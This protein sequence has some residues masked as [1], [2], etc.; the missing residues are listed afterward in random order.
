MHV[1]GSADPATTAAL[2]HEMALTA[3]A[4][5]A[6]H[7]GPRRLWAASV[8][9]G[10]DDRHIPRRK[11]D[12]FPREDGELYRRQWEAA[13]TSHSDQVLVVSFNEWME[14]TNIEPNAAWGDQYLELTSVLAARF[15]DR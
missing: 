2:D 15:R 3:R 9:P 5:A 6:V 8:L 13:T 14:T 4:W 12:H 7:G 11:P 1:Y 10:Y